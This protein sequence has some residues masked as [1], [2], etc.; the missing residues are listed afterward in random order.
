MNLKQ[1]FSVVQPNS[2]RVLWDLQQML[3]V[4]GLLPELRVRVAIHHEMHMQAECRLES[5]L[6]A[7]SLPRV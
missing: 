5:L 7:F 3:T 1:T 4:Q 2:L 6:F